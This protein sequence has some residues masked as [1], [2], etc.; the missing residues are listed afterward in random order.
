MQIFT[1]RVFA[2]VCFLARAVSR[3]EHFVP[4][5]TYLKHV[6]PD[7]IQGELVPRGAHV[8]P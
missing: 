8:P 6:I 1:Y 3:Q 7:V 4:P 2:C 5:D